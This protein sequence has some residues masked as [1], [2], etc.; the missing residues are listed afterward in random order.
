[1]FNEEF[2]RSLYLMLKSDK[3]N[4]EDIVNFIRSVPLELFQQIYIQLEKY[5]K[6]EECDIDILDREDICLYGNCN[7]KYGLKYYF[8]L[9]MIQN[10]ITIG[11]GN[12][13]D[14]DF[15]KSYEITLYAESRYNSIDLFSSQILGNVI[16]HSNDSK[17]EYELVDGLLGKMVVYTNNGSLKKYKKVGKNVDTDK[18]DKILSGRG[19][20]RV[21]KLN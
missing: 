15:V 2:D 11:V 16:N 10:S 9:D 6:Y 18:L 14:M 20:S 4:R 8:I 13:I 19:I 7:G 12:I 1:M 17:T 21:R 3:N 5:E